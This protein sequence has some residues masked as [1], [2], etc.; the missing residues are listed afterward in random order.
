MS[1]PTLNLGREH[2]G[3]LASGHPWIYRDRLPPHRLATGAWVR[4]EAGRMS[5]IGLFDAEGQ[6]GVRLFDRSDVPDRAL[7]RA[8]VTE[9]LALRERIPSTDTDAYRL[10]YGEGD[11]V[12]GLV[13]DRYGRYAV[14]KSY[15]ASVA[16]HASAVA[17]AA[18]RALGLRG[19]VTRHGEGLRTLWGSAPPPELSVREN[20]LTFVANL[21]RGQ[22]TG[23]F[24]DQRDNRQ[25]VRGLASGRRVLNLFSYSGAFGVYAL[26]GGAD[27]V[28]DVD[29]AEGA[30]ADAE[31][32]VA[33]NGF[34][35][36]QHRTVAADAAEF[37]RRTRDGATRYDLVILDPP[38]LARSKGKRRAAQRAYR[39]LNSAALRVVAPGGLLASASCTSQVGPEAF[40]E[41]LREAA[42][43]AGVR[44]Q[45]VHEAGH[46]CDHPVP[47][48]FPEGRYLKFVVMRVLPGR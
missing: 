37:L 16:A 32:N 17:E 27:H 40:L 38:S 6:I 26:A 23:L 15:A 33:A 34:A 29:V 43:E 3:L 46:A 42:A 41:A 21:E 1:L 25:T 10:L 31:R 48:H 4:V 18:G 11:G 45:I 13:I 7:W 12:P 39:K 20:G 47:L 24:L 22:K 35:A 44:A 5:A 9:A 19:V 30:L 14:A 36:E 2:E 8:R 28:T